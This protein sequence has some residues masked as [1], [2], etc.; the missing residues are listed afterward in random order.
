MNNK[1]LCYDYW[2]HYEDMDTASSSLNKFE[3]LS[4]LNNIVSYDAPSSLQMGFQ[5]PASPMMEGIID[6][7]HDLFFFII[8]ISVF[9]S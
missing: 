7:H 8:L 9:V 6:L 5:D 1:P 2:V 3:N 4:S